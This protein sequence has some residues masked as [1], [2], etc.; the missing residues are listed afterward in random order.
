MLWCRRTSL[1]LRFSSSNAA[2][3][4]LSRHPYDRQTPPHYFASTSLP[5]L[6]FPAPMRRASVLPCVV[7][8]A[9]LR[10]SLASF[11]RL[12]WEIL[13]DF[14]RASITRQILLS[15]VPGKIL[16]HEVIDMVVN[17]LADEK[18]ILRWF[19]PIEFSHMAL[20]PLEYDESR[21]DYMRERYM[22]KYEDVS[23]VHIPMIRDVHWFLLVI[24]AQFDMMT[25][26]YS[27]KDATERQGRIK[28]LKAMANF[29]QFLLDDRRF[30]EHSH[31]K[32]PLISKFKFIEA[33][34]PQQSLD[35]NDGR[36]WVARWMQ[37]SYMWDGYLDHVD[38]KTC[39]SIALELVMGKH[40]RKAEQIQ[41]MA[42]K[43][44]DKIVCLVV[45][46]EKSKRKRL[47]D[48]ESELTRP[49]GWGC[50]RRCS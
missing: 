40:N 5:R 12:R 44:W 22:G 9:V 38:A 33:E 18:D 25:Y 35:S 11:S 49:L 13:V 41:E 43:T 45:P 16:K 1:L 37:S 17:N 24:D 14:E 15:L 6:G 2:S 7:L 39:M 46:S 4:L 50:F 32:K 3:R 36:I 27:L 26:Y 48:K 20:H 30:F 8:P 34:S 10:C 42:T 21:I 29:L 23:K 47:E 28:Q 19:L 31:T